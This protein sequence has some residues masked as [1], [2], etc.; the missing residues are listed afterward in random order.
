M[1]NNANP[2]DDSGVYSGGSKQTVEFRAPDGSADVYL[3]MA[4]LVVATQH[5]LE[6]D[7]ALKIAE[8][9]YV[10]VNIFKEEN[11]EARNKLQSL[12]TSCYESADEL[13]KY[14]LFYEKGDVFPSGTIDNIIS[15]LKS[16]NDK[17]LSERLYGKNEEIAE[18]VNKYLH[19]S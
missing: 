13:N 1:V 14:R 16:F 12:P 18:L 15:K 6:K 8:E 3:L 17:E 9:L 2:L 11:L 7:D 4:G 19:C 5:G 10:S